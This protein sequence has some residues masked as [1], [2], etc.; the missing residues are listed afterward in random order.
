M[1]QA[2]KMDRSTDACKAHLS[3]SSKMDVRQTRKGWFQELLGCEA[4]TELNY[5]TEDKTKIAT[6]VEDT[7]CFC[8]MCCT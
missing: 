5:F 4:K 3:G 2:Q 7:D 6:S 8:R 1:V